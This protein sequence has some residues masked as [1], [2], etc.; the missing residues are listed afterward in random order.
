M[1]GVSLQFS[2]AMSW[3]MVAVEVYFICYLMFA[4]G[5]TNSQFY[6]GKRQMVAGN[7]QFIHC[8]LLAYGCYQRA[9]FHSSVSASGSYQF[10]DYSLPCTW[11]WLLSIC[12]CPQQYISK[13]LL[14]I[15]LQLPG[16]LSQQMGAINLRSIRYL[17]SANG[18]YQ[19]A[20]V[21]TNALAN[22]C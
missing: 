10:A 9:V 18:C 20:V 5:A 6:V 17:V 19:F 2:A 3:Q 11:K 13:W 7:V 14:A 1:V 8:I 15:N 21:H 22:G 12:S 16:V 4:K